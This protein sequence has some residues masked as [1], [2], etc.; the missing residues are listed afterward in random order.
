MP[1]PLGGVDLTRR[2]LPSGPPSP[3]PGET[4]FRLPAG[5]QVDPVGRARLRATS[6]GVDF[7]T[8]LARRRLG[9]RGRWNGQT[10]R[11]SRGCGGDPRR[12]RGP[13]ESFACR[14]VMWWFDCKQLIQLLRFSLTLC[15]KATT[16]DL[17]LG[18]LIRQ[19][20]ERFGKV[21]ANWTV[22]SVL[23]LLG[24]LVIEQALS[25][26]DLLKGKIV[27]EGGE[28]W[29]NIFDEVIIFGIYLA[30]LCIILKGFD[31]YIKRKMEDDKKWNNE[32]KDRIEGA[33]THLE[34]RKDEIERE[35]RALLEARKVVKEKDQEA[36]R[37]IT[38]AARLVEQAAH[39]VRVAQGQDVLDHQQ[40]D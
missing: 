39:L 8:A 7:A 6:E 25:V 9:S 24:L 28:I 17:G 15:D 40:Q 30:I 11:S 27:K 26:Y 18:D 22:G 12:R 13:Q 16:M 33:I 35:E 38:E 20:E 36:D 19:I 37:K 23:F 34:A 10:G 5:R 21:T 31:I 32:V 1:L 14:P 2:M 3:V 29:R 4:P